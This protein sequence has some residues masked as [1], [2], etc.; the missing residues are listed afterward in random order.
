M[1][2]NSNVSSSIP[3][4]PSVKKEEKPVQKG[5]S[6]Q[7]YFWTGIGAIATYKLFDD[8]LANL[9]NLETLTHGTGPKG[10]IG[11]SLFGADPNYG[12]SSSG[13][14]Q[15]INN[16]NH[17][18]R[19]RN[20]FHVF[21]DSEYPYS[22]FNPV[23]WLTPKVL[24]RMHAILS[25]IATFG[26]NV[27]EINFKPIR[28]MVGAFFGAITPTLKFRFRPED[29]VGCKTNCRFENDPD[30]MDMAY[31]TAHRISPLHLGILGSVIQGVN[32]TMLYRMASNPLKVL[33]GGCILLGAYRV[34]K[35]TYHYF[36]Q[37]PPELLESSETKDQLPA[38]APVKPTWKD[39]AKKI[40]KACLWATVAA[41]VV[42]I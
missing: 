41:G 25:G 27:D 9:L 5:R 15:G 20:Y 26:S 24:P 33:K 29:I 6:C 13:S 40:P 8:G 7:K 18:N 34:G 10:F 38:Q 35:A 32:P 30:Y 37:K 23:Y 4:D 2:V 1:E 39:T 14:S 11:I 42:L 16:Q 31:R 28:T 22:A 17:V 12:G 36:K 19:S 21:K 3:L